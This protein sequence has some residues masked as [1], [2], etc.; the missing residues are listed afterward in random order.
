MASAKEKTTTEV[1]FVAELM[2]AAH[3]REEISRNRIAELEQQLAA[4]KALS[5]AATTPEAMRTLVA[6]GISHN[7]IQHVFVTPAQVTLKWLGDTGVTSMHVYKFQ[8][9]E[10]LLRL[11]AGVIS[12][13]IGRFFNT[14]HRTVGEYMQE[15]VLEQFRH[16]T[17]SNF[18][19]HSQTREGV[20]TESETT[21]ANAAGSLPR[22]VTLENVPIFAYS[23]ILE[24]PPQLHCEL[25][26]TVRHFGD[27]EF[28]MRKLELEASR[29]QLDEVWQRGI[30]AHLQ[31]LL[32]DCKQNHIPVIE[33]YI[34]Q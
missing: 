32:D 2:Q 22:Y 30:H 20:N 17:L 3:D 9:S 25:S 27:G 33:G 1:Q 8:A 29:Q 31:P 4:G 24:P 13:E 26:L 14:L 11:R 28:L 16:L 19:R 34:S 10:P 6:M 23:G 12:D 7:L 18:T 15:D 21:L 5:V